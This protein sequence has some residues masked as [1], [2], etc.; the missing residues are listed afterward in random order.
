MKGHNFNSRCGESIMINGKLEQFL[1]TN[2]EDYIK[3]VVYFANNIEG[4]AKEREK[5]FNNI[6]KTTLFNSKEYALNL[7]SE[8]LKIYNRKLN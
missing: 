2:E 3:K 8:I 1:A 7:K 4:L 6:L 5:I